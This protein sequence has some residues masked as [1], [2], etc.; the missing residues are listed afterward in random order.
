[1]GRTKLNAVWAA[2]HEQIDHLRRTSR[3]NAWGIKVRAATFFFLLFNS[4][5]TFDIIIKRSEMSPLFFTQL[6]CHEGDT[7]VYEHE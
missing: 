1:M 5:H 3:H 4:L 7:S 6:S 2:V